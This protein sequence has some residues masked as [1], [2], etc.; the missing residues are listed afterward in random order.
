M[1]KTMGIY[2]KAYQLKQ[3]R[4]FAGWHE[5]ASAARPAGDQAGAAPRILDG[6]SV[7]YLQENLA[8][9][10]GIFKD[11]HVLFSAKSQVWAEFCRNELEFV[12]PEDVLR[13]AEV[14]A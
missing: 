1:T 8:V 13:A 12:I 10:D 11:A 4:A 7:V 3:L 2:C 14:A 6:E 5:N 9:T